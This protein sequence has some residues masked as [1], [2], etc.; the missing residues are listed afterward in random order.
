MCKPY[1]T[2]LPGNVV[3][4][5]ALGGQGEEQVLPARPRCGAPVRRPPLPRLVRFV[6]D[7]NYDLVLSDDGRVRSLAHVHNLNNRSAALRSLNFVNLF[8]L[9]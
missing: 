6:G 8:D 3:D 5:G 9:E 2:Y 4:F 1:F 7:F